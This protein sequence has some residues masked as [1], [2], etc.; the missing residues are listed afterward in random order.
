MC[1]SVCVCVRHSS[2]FASHAP[3]VCREMCV[4]EYECNTQACM[5]VYLSVYH[6]SVSASREAYVCWEVCGL[7]C[8]CLSFM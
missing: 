2:V 3:C 4:L 8:E 1:V 6:S 5:C 7:E